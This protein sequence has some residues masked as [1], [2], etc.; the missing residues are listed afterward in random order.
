MDRS[1]L[2]MEIDRGRSASQEKKRRWH[3]RLWSSVLSLTDRSEEKQGRTGKASARQMVKF[4]VSV[5]HVN[6]VGGSQVPC[7]MLRTSEPGCDVRT[8]GSVTAEEFEMS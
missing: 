1:S 7:Q 8:R 3:K 6:V 5:G 2:G 4:S